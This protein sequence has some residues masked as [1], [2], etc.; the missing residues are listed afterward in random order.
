MVDFSV[1]Y[2]LDILDVEALLREE[3]ECLVADLTTMD[4]S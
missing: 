1:F 2:I 3:F 4:L